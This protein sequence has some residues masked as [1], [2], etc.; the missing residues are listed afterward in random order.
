[1][2]VVW[3]FVMVITPLNLRLSDSSLAAGVIALFFS[4]VVGQTEAFGF[5]R[6]A[7][8]W[9][10]CILVPGY[11]QKIWQTTIAIVAFYVG[12]GVLL[13]FTFGNFTPPF[14]F[15]AMLLMGSLALASYSRR[16]GSRVAN[17]CLTI[18]LLSVMGSV[19]LIPF[20]SPESR[21]NILASVS[22]LMIQVPALAVAVY[23]A[24]VLKKEIASIASPVAKPIAG[25]WDQFRLEVASRFRFGG[26][27]HP[28][29]RLAPVL[30]H[31]IPFFVIVGVSHAAFTDAGSDLLE[32]S[33]SRWSIVVA[34][35]VYIGTGTPFGLLKNPGLWLSNTWQFGL[36]K[37]RTSL[38]SEFVVRVLKACIVPVVL[39]FGIALVHAMNIEAPSPDWRGYANFYD[40]ALLL[41][42]INLLCFTWAC[43]SYP[44]RISECPEFIHIRIAL[45]AAACLVFIP[46][47]EFGLVVRVL[48]LIAV[49][50][51]ATL[52]IYVGG[53]SIA[54][55][56][57]TPIK[58]VISPLY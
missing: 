19:I 54:K 2:I 51:S 6:R 7:M 45:C 57:F 24:L 15:A 41:I 8:E 42:T 44:R 29:A 53:R 52:A 27:V 1:M 55:I 5:M 33:A 10:A 32:S 17:I 34:I 35:F 25:A 31:L 58:K 11:S 50:C 43:T 22:S 30:L 23:A 21:S 49:I 56:D 36:G 9:E 38:G 37:S 3:L 20:G 26:W 16:T 28:S 18:G 48:L 40:E 13:S 39:V 14:G 47:V 4:Y 46:G 12:L